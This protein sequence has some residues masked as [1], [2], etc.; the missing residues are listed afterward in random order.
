MK[1]LIFTLTSWDEAPRA[2]HQVTQELIKLGH[3]VYFV[4]KNSAGF[5]KIKLK[6]MGNL[7]L[8]KTR[9]LPGYR[10]R[11]R[12]PLINGLYQWWLFRQLRAKLGDLFVITFDFTAHKL[13][14]YFT[15][16]VYYCNDEVVGNTTVSSSLVDMYWRRCESSVA[17]NANL[18]V[19]TA[20]FLAQKLARF[21]RYVYEIPLGGPDPE[22]IETVAFHAQTDRVV[23][24]LVGFIREI[25]I[26]TSVINDLLQDHNLIIRIAGTVD[27]KF[28]N[29][30]E[31][32]SGIELLGVL[33]DQSLYDAVSQFDVAII[34]YDQEKLNP[35]ATSNKLYI[36]LSCGVPV[37]MSSMPNLK[38]KT[39]PEGTVYLSEDN[40]DFYDL[41]KRALKQ[42]KPQYR[43]LRKK[44][45]SENTWE[46]RVNLFIKILKERKLFR[47]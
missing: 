39:F 4:E 41:V 17:R 15:N 21:N 13:T 26:S 32:P 7:T 42:E 20:P 3:E 45:A 24:G 19:A 40:S 28:M 2:R 38:G 44:V 27:E 12:A 18:C 33:K 22:K 31:R 5:P 6:K 30:I 23:L 35:G 37:V 46:M 34:P 10:I 29:K 1:F 43:V 9:F 25:T 11:F 47:D 14:K 36:Y 8:V 16:T